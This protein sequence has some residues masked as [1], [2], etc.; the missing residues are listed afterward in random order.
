MKLM[1]TEQVLTV[2]GGCTGAAEYRVVTRFSAMYGGAHCGYKLVELA[3]MTGGSTLL[4]G[5]GGVLI[6]GAFAYTMAA[7]QFA[8]RD[9]V[10][11]VICP[12]I[13]NVFFKPAELSPAI[14][15]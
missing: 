15:S 1:T 14:A 5:C 4:A 13:D 3:L 10:G 7:V 12:V 11:D 8:I 6:G 2:S 9:F